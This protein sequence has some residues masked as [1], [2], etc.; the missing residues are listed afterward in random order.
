MTDDEWRADKEFKRDKAEREC[1]AAADPKKERSLRAK[2]DNYKKMLTIGRE[3]MRAQ[4]RKAAQSRR[5]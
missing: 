1:A 5:A 3:G 4:A 2:L